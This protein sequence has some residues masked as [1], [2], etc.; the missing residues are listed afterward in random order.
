MTLMPAHKWQL[1]QR[2]LPTQSLISDM[3]S[4]LQDEHHL[5]RSL[6]FESHPSHL[7]QFQDRLGVGLLEGIRMAAVRVHVLATASLVAHLPDLRHQAFLPLQ[8]PCH[9]RQQ[10]VYWDTYILYVSIYIYSYTCFYISQI[11]SHMPELGVF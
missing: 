2:R 3:I 10:Q 8:G 4:C 11:K 9:L 5:H 7:P 6:F 1:E